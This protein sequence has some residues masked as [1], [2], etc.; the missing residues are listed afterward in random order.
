MYC[1][2]VASTIAKWQFKIST[3]TLQYGE[4]HMSYL[5]L[6]IQVPA[7][8]NLKELPENCC[9]HIH[10]MGRSIG[11]TVQSLTSNNPVQS[12]KNT[13]EN[14]KNPNDIRTSWSSSSRTSAAP[15]FCRTKLN[16]STQTSFFLWITIPLNQSEGII[17]QLK[18]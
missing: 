2:S 8:F 15:S 16:N 7:T 13:E 6:F 4:D 14:S 18:E 9:R 1:L 5:F 12:K 10:R 11:N 3:V 17:C